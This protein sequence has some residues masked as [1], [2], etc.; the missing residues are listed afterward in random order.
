MEILLSGNAL[1]ECFLEVIAQLEHYPNEKS[2]E[3]RISVY[4]LMEISLQNTK[5]THKIL[6]KKIPASFH[7]TV[8]DRTEPNLPNTEAS[9]RYYSVRFGEIQ[10]YRTESFLLLISIFEVLGI[11]FNHFYKKLTT[12]N[13]KFSTKI[14]H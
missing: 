2:N 9:V 13:Q 1:I 5:R 10:E 3:Y 14:S 11:C 6:N 12:F 8:V 7:L 4:F